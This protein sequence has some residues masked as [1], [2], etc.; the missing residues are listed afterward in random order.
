MLD[1][2]RRF[3]ERLD[4]AWSRKNFDEAAFP[5]LALQA[6]ERAHLHEGFTPE[7]LLRELLLSD[8][9]FPQNDGTFGEPPIVVWRGRGWFIE[10]LY[11]LD[12]TTDIHTHAFSGAFQV[13]SGSSIHT[14]WRFSRRAAWC[15]AGPNSPPPRRFASTQTPPL[16]SQPLPTKPEYEG[17]CETS[18]PP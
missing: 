3:G 16:A 6:L 11:W 1:R 17:T 12:A 2:F 7:A 4:A 18:K 13:L 15:Q 9:G 8:P 14:T 10:V 5:E